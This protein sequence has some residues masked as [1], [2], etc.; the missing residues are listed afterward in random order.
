MLKYDF[1]VLTRD[2]QKIESLVIAGRDQM[3]AERKLFQMYRHCT[4]LRCN[5]KNGE[6]KGPAASIEEILSLISR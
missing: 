1:S 4:V 3:D 2:G 6:A 5:V